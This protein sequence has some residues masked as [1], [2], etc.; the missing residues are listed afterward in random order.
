MSKVR[1]K[2]PSKGGMPH[3]SLPTVTP[4]IFSFYYQCFNSR[5]LK[6]LAIRTR[7]L[8]HELEA[9]LFRFILVHLPPGFEPAAHAGDIFKSVL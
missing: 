7:N 3:F 2:E 8:T 1:A 4:M 6:S 5:V 9:I